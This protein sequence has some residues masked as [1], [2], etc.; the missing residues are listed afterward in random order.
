MSYSIDKF[1]CPEIFENNYDLI[2]AIIDNS[3]LIRGNIKNP[4]FYLI[5]LNDNN[6]IKNLLNYLNI[7][8]SNIILSPD[9]KI[10]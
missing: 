1:I 7:D 8:H 4:G 3:V 5:N 2:P 10:I 6:S 9:K